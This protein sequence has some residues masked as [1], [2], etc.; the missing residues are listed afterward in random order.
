MS[1]T[2][3]FTGTARLIGKREFI[4]SPHGKMLASPGAVVVESEDGR[5]VFIMERDDYVALFNRDVPPLGEGDGEMQNPPSDSDLPLEG[6]ATEPEYDGVPEDPGDPEPTGD[7][8]WDQ[9]APED[10]EGDPHYAPDQSDPDD[11]I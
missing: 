3:S 10:R 4:R 2:F 7:E 6:T 9:T 1:E 11:R 8:G 5:A